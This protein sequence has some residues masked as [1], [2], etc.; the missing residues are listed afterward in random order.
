MGKKLT[1]E[2]FVSRATK[3]HKGKYNYSLVNYTTNKDPVIIICP[4]H[5]QFLQ[6]PMNH[7]KGVGCKHCYHES[8]LG[9]PSNRLGKTLKRDIMARILLPEPTETTNK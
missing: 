5:G 9:R 6:L 2:Q 4:V 1:T 8:Q 3:V 7:L